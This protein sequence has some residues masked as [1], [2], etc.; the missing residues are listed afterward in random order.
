MEIHPL[1]PWSQ[2]KIVRSDHVRGSSINGRCLSL[3]DGRRNGEPG[4]GGNDR[5]MVDDVADM[6]YWGEGESA[7]GGVGDDTIEASTTPIMEP[8]KAMNAA[9]SR[10]QEARLQEMGALGL[11]AMA[12]PRGR[13]KRIALLGA[14]LVVAVLVAC[15]A[16]SLTVRPA[17]ARMVAHARFPITDLGTLPGGHRSYAYDINDRGQ[18]VG[19]RSMASGESHAFLWESRRGTGHWRRGGR[20]DLGTLGGA[21][22]QASAIN[23]RGQVV[24]SSYIEGRLYN[25]DHS[26]L[27]EKGR[28]KD[29]GTLDPQGPAHNQQS[30][31]TAINDREQ[32]V[33][34]S[35]TASGLYRA[36]VWKKGKMT[37]LTLKGTPE[38]TESNARDLNDRGQIVGNW[39]VYDSHEPHASLWQRGKRVDLGT[40]RGGT[41]SG[42][43]GINNRGQVVGGSEVASG[44]THAVLWGKRVTHQRRGSPPAVED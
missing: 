14:V 31:A 27:W 43:S 23:N 28:M 6:N 32:V 26:F 12:I 22:A 35:E 10:G 18:V 4:R 15:V 16:I 9:P 21:L 30:F 38:E 25:P 36:F 34:H 44:Y 2:A 41:V 11:D 19:S 37:A 29:L 13:D 42:A 7:E 3:A 20:K 39:T 17:S 40:L 24:G 33:G 8:E 1:A 5:I